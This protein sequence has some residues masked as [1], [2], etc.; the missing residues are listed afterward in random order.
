[1][2]AIGINVSDKDST[3]DY[4]GLRTARKLFPELQEAR[5]EAEELWARVTGEWG[6]SMLAVGNYDGVEELI[7]QAQAAER[8]AHQIWLQINCAHEYDQEDAGCKHCG[9]DYFSVDHDSSISDI[10]A[11]IAI[12]RK[13][14][15]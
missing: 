5:E 2:S 4:T 13:G 15:K 9:A 12:Q 8:R 11:D 10:E 7:D 3:Y 1:M 6:E 14:E